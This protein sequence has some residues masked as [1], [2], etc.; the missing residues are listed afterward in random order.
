MKRS[1]SNIIASMFLVLTLA[2]LI[3]FVNT[4]AMT[5]NSGNGT[6]ENPH[7]L[8][9][10]YCENDAFTYNPNPDKPEKFCISSTF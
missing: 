2:V 10:G 5:S 7:Q 3:P 6:E 8:T 4:N 1:I 9:I